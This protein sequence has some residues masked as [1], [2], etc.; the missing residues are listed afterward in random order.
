MKAV[1]RM[2]RQRNPGPADPQ[3][4]EPRIALRS[5]RATALDL[6]YTPRTTVLR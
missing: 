6:R 2:E 1:A 3:M 5:I 4:K